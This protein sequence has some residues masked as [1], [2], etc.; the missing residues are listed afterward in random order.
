M[1]KLCQ[2]HLCEQYKRGLTAK[3]SYKTWFLSKKNAHESQGI[4]VKTNLSQGGIHCWETIKRP[5]NWNKREGVVNGSLNADYDWAAAFRFRS[6]KVKDE[7]SYN[8]LKAK[9]VDPIGN[10]CGFT[11]QERLWPCWKKF[12]IL[13]SSN[14]RSKRR[15]TT[16][17]VNK[18]MMVG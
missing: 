13:A 14:A 11:W 10:I 9:S 12:Q 4:S 5:S 16:R 18:K 1:L 6:K 8:A 7:I 15:S 17:R 2:F 3:S